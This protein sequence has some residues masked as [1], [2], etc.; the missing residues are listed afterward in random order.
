MS[1]TNDEAAIHG[2]RERTEK[3]ENDGDAAF[4]ET[5]AADDIVVMPPNM[6]VV[7]GRDATVRFMREFLGG[8]D[9]EIHYVSEE[10]QVRGDFAFDRGTYT[11]TLTPNG[12]GPAIPGS[13]N[14]LWIYARAAD[15]SWKASRVIWNESDP[16]AGR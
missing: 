1:S 2:L 11:Q 13:G 15:D 12:G 4:F 3:A 10:I 6:P 8:F 5:L 9:L 14:Y 16:A 7:K